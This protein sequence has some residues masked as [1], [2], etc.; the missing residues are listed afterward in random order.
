MHFAY[1]VGCACVKA[2]LLVPVAWS[3]T[4]QMAPILLS[5]I[6]KLNRTHRVKWHT[7]M[8]RSYVLSILQPHH[9][10]DACFCRVQSSV[11][12]SRQVFFATRPG[13]MQQAH[14]AKTVAAQNAS[15]SHSGG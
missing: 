2:S 11:G 5:R 12:G 7:A 10:A 1:A 3:S 8:P 9:Q 6:C 4:K 14:H 15:K 13:W